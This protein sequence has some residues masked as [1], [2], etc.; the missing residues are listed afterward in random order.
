M[1]KQLLRLALRPANKTFV[2]SF[3]NL[4]VLLVLPRFAPGHHCKLSLF[5]VVSAVLTCL[6]RVAELVPKM[7]RVRLLHPGSDFHPSPHRR[8]VWQELPEAV[9]LL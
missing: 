2:S 8:L 5:S 6:P 3:R 7:G 9:A 4:V 1:L